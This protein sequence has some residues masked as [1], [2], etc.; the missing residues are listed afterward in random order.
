MLVIAVDNAPQR[1]RGRLPAGVYV[2]QYSRRVCERIR[3]DVETFGGD[4]DAVMAWTAPY[5]QG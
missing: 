3:K 2:G 1:L 5:D 4:G